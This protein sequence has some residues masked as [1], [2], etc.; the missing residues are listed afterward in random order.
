MA[1]GVSK[2][3]TVQDFPDMFPDELPGLPSDCKVEFAIEFYH[4]STSVLLMT[5]RMAPKQLKIQLQK[6]LDKDWCVVYFI[7]DIPVCSQTEEEHN[8]HL[9]IVLQILREKQVFMKY[10]KCEFWL[11]EVT[12]FWHIVSAKGVHMDPKKIKEFTWTEERQ[13]SFNKLKDI[14][15]KALVLIQPKPEKEFMIYKDASHRRL[16]CV[17]MQKGKVVAYAL[18][19]LKV[20]ERNYQTHDL[21]LA[22]V[23]FELK[24]WQHY[25]IIEKCTI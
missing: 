1:K 11:K 17:L 23:V 10:N 5:Y 4:S 24:I 7:D 19:K 18:R 15:T 22:T 13:Q 25:L 8:T 20:R 14:L 9:R 2:M 3:R 12:F 6:L 21:E 16:R